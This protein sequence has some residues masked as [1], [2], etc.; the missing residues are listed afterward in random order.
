MRKIVAARMAAAALATAFAVSGCSQITSL[1]LKKTAPAETT[2][3]VKETTEEETTEEEETLSAEQ[4][5][6]VKYNNYVEL[7]ND[8]IEILDNIDYYYVVVEDAEEFALIPDSGHTYGYRIRKVGSDIVD[9]CLQLSDMEPAFETLD[10]LVKEMA[11]P[12]KSLME[13][14]YEVSG[15]HDYADNQ[16]QKAKELHAVIHSLAPEFEDAGYRYLD[17]VNVIANERIAEEEEQMKADGKLIAYNAS[18]GITVAGKI[19]DECKR[20]GVTD[21]NITQLDLSTIRPLYDELVA[22]VKDLDAASADNDQMIKESM[23]NSRPFDGIY[24][25]LIQALEWMIGQ[26]ESGK[27]IEDISL[28]PLGSIAHFSNTLSKCIDRYN[29]L[30]VD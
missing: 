9:D 29:T 28:E 6:L 7:N 19:I 11:E 1:D 30:F 22:T 10:P 2:G 21:A 23:R 8:I 13:A 24:D 15:S 18:H 16:Y 25:S 3:T 4:M 14:F 20:Q 12:L 27:P 5:E 26:V 17:A